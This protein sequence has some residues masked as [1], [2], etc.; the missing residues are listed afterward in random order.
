MTPQT[1]KRK[2]R[3]AMRT[4]DHAI[5]HLG[6]TNTCFMLITDGKVSHLPATTR[7]ADAAR[8]VLVAAMLQLAS[9]ITREENSDARN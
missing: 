1:L 2:Q 5:D 7:N 8:A 9:D 4:L 3:Q 6:P